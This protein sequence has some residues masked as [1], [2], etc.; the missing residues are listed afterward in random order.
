MSD[1]SGSSGDLRDFQRSRW[2]AGERIPAEVL[3]REHPDIN[4]NHDVAVD[5]IYGEYLLREELGEHP[6]ID[7]FARRFPQFANTLR[8]QIAIHDAMRTLPTGDGGTNPIPSP[9]DATL[10][11][12]SVPHSNSGQL[13]QTIG[14]YTIIDRLGRGGM[15]TVYLAHDPQLE[16]RVALKVPLFDDGPHGRTAAWFRREAKIAATLTHPNFCPVYDVGEHD[17]QLFITMP[18]IAGETLASRL[19]RG[20]PVPCREAVAWVIKIARAL[21]E[22]HRA[23]IVPRDLKPSNIMIDARGEP[24]VMDFGLARREAPDVDLATPFG[25]IV[26][27]PAYLAPEQIAGPSTPAGDVYSLGVLFYQMLSGKPPYSGKFEDVLRSAIQGN[28]P[29]P[30]EIVPGIDP[31]TE[32]I[33]L[34]A[35][36]ADPLDRFDSMDAFANALLTPKTVPIEPPTAKTRRNRS[37][38]VIAAIAIITLGAAIG[39]SLWFR[40]AQSPADALQAGSIWSGKFHF[41]PPA[42]AYVGEVSLRITEREGDRF[43]ATYSTESGDYQWKAIGTVQKGEIAFGFESAIREKEPRDVVGRA[44]VYGHLEGNTAKL[45]FDH[46]IDGVAD[47][48][49]TRTNP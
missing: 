41:R 28:P 20:G 14:R 2:R 17:G 37:V 27:T 47:I 34:K 29:P 31:H 42:G 9:G 43:V 5:I 6:N 36:D 21:A 33:C 30:S 25:M 23:G 1:A 46:G 16:R 8:D 4:S 39:W 44:K 19:A 40:P 38:M 11:T 10:H 26:G 7:E 45:V 18:F 49:L 3:L 32:A 35:M 15:G 24:I 12:H 22:A 13:P 48:E